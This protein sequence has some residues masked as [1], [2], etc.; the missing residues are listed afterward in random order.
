[1]LEEH[2][3]GFVEKMSDDFN[4]PGALATLQDLTRQVNTLLNERSSLTLATL[5]AIDG[6]Y[7]RL[8][9]DVLGVIPAAADGGAGGGA[10]AEREAGLIRMLIEL[11]TQARANKDWATS[12]KIR[13]QLKGLGVALEDRPD[14][15][16]W[17][18][19]R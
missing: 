12:D 7:R 17:K 5:Q 1:M 18:I 3:A 9:G 11:R 6:V 14:G 4:A 15:T 8:G 16:I 13:D 2:T 19:D 10:D